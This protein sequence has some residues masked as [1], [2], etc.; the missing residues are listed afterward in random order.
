VG[1]VRPGESVYLHSS[2]CADGWERSVF[3]DEVFWVCSEDKK[4]GDV[5]FYRVCRFPFVPGWFLCRLLNCSTHY[6]FA[7]PFKTLKAAKTAVL[8]CGEVDDAEIDD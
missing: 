5:R 8:V 1:D 3:S 7:G 4:F 6:P 2:Q